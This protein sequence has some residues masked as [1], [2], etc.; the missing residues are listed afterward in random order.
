MNELTFK[1]HTFTPVI[2]NNLP[3]L[4]VP[5]I[6][7]ALNYRSGKLLQIYNRHADEFTPEMSTIL[8]LKAV[9]G[10]M[11]DVRV[12]SLRGCHLL[13]MFS[14]TPVAKEFRRWVL[15]LIEQQN[16]T[17]PKMEIATSDINALG[18]LFRSSLKQE[19]A[20]LASASATDT[21]TQDM[22]NLVAALM[23]NI[24][25]GRVKNQYRHLVDENSLL[26]SKLDAIRRA[27]LLPAK[28]QMSE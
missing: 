6:E 28:T 3:F 13:A 2:V 1:S 26:R 5:Q 20:A 17:V 21:D 16:R 14:K 23:N 25:D 4:R 11:R 9:D 27:A 15:D 7:D 24:I 22:R 19:L 8:K 18:G 10:K 12:F